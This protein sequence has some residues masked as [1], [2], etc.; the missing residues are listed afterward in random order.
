MYF[1]PHNT[2]HSSALT[3]DLPVWMNA[4]MLFMTRPF[5]SQD[6]DVKNCVPSKSQETRVVGTAWRGRRSHEDPLC[7]SDV[8]VG[9]GGTLSLLV[10]CVSGVN[11][12]GYIP[13]LPSDWPIARRD[14]CVFGARVREKR[15]LWL[16]HCHVNT[17]QWSTNR[18]NMSLEWQRTH[19][20]RILR[21]EQMPAGTIRVLYN[22]LA[23]TVNI[24]NG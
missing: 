11:Y 2:S 20:Q 14:L 17:K 13:H 3:I 7:L 6:K 21:F 8:D 16:S 12:Q 5:R 22:R 24:N 9:C 18:G 1:S 23:Y 15:G 4:T 10:C 19:I